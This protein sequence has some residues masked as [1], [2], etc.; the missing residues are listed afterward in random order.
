MRV[1]KLSDLTKSLESEM[2]TIKKMMTR[3]NTFVLIFGNTNKITNKN[4]ETAPDIT[5]F[6]VT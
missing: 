6:L 4:N 3:M 2:Y 1:F 5:T